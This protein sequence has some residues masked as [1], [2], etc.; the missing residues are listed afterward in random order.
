M[1]L[2]DAIYDKF[3]VRYKEEVQKL[4]AGDPKDPSTTL[5]PLISQAA[6][7]RL[8][9]QVAE[10]KKQGVSIETIGAPVPKQGFF[11]QPILMTG[12]E[13]KEVRK[14][15]FFGPVSQFYRV[16]TIR[17]AIDLANESE[18]GLSGSVHTANEAHGLEIAQAIDSG[19]FVVNSAFFT[20]PNAPFGG[21]KNS[22][23]GRD[24]AHDGILEFMNLKLINLHK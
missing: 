2:M 3:L 18:Y 22:G 9:Q 11:F 6:L 17:E 15:E 5:G 4:K 21:V 10:A 1:I 12:L 8:N 13:G 20:S 23:Y 16:K 19:S 14:E 7:D 24:L